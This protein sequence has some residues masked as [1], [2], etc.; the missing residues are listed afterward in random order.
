MLLP[1]SIEANTLKGFQQTIAVS[2]IDI[3]LIAHILSCFWIRFNYLD[4]DYNYTE[5]YVNAFYFVFATASTVGYG[6]L[7]VNKNQTLIEARYL[8]TILMLFL[9]LI[10]FAYVQSLITTILGKLKKLGSSSQEALNELE[11]WLATR[12]RSAKT[13]MPYQL[14]KKI[15][16]Y[17]KFREEWDLQNILYQF[18]F[19]EK[20]SIKNQQ[21][22]SD[23]MVKEITKKF[24]G[25][26]KDLSPMLRTKVALMAKL[27]K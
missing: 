10:F 5:N 21:R 1:Y 23:Y 17:F 15:F 9:A 19:F 8:F 24:K 2:I 27:I 25:F 13:M 3:F 6:D 16:R 20:N 14:E 22:I 18:D 26:F 11:D 12:N 7:T 4:L